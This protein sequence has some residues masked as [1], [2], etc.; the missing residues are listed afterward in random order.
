MSLSVMCGSD[1]YSKQLNTHKPGFI[2]SWGIMASN[3]PLLP[4]RSVV[5]WLI[6][7]IFNCGPLTNNVKAW[8]FGYA[9][10]STYWW[11]LIF[12][13]LF[14]LQCAEARNGETLGKSRKDVEDY[15]NIADQWHQGWFTAWGWE[16]L[17][18]NCQD[19]SRRWQGACGE[20]CHHDL[21][22]A[23]WH[24]LPG[25]PLTVHHW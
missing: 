13:L 20:I 25:H 9:Y 7:F 3:N 24:C 4:L 6:S 8:P 21:Q 1:K 18:H 11:R 23:P 15:M 12:L 10:P 22:E 16:S 2:W 19:L 14:R 17:R 5:T